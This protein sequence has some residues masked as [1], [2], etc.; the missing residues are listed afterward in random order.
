MTREDVEKAMIGDEII[1]EINYL[2]KQ[3][4]NSNGTVREVA[5]KML[6]GEFF[7][8]CDERGDIEIN[9]M[10]RIRDMAVECLRQMLSKLEKQLEEL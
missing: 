6:D 10:Q 8:L 3:I 4:K 9:C 1:K 2:E 5:I 7:I